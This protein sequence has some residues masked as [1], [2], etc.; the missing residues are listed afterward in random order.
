VTAQDSAR[1]GV[2][3]ATFDEVAALDPAGRKARLDAIG[4]ADPALLHAIEQLLAS[5]SSAREVLARFES[6]LGAG[7]QADDPLKLVGQVVSHFRV[8]ECIGRGGMGVVYRA[9]DIQLGRPVAVKVPLGARGAD[10]MAIERFRREARV[11]AGLEHPN[12]C[13]VYETGETPDG[14]LFYVMPFYQGE[15]LKD[16]ITRR[17]TIPIPEALG[18][19]T[20]IAGGLV[21]LHKAGI[22][23]RDLKPANVMRLEDGGVRI[24]DFGL[25]KGSDATLTAT[26]AL[27]GTIA[28]MAPEQVNGEKVDQRADLWA[29]GVVLFE[30]VTGKRPFSGSDIGAVHAI[31]HQEA[32][33]ASRHSDGVPP[34]LDDCLHRC[35]Q[36]DPG[37]RYQSAEELLTALGAIRVNERPGPLRKVRL[38]QASLRRRLTRPVPLILAGAALTALVVLVLPRRG[39]QAEPD[40]PVTVQ[41]LAILA[42]SRDADHPVDDYLVAGFSDEVASLLSRTHTVSVAARGSAA[43]LLQQGLAPRAIG[44]RLNVGHVLEA[45]FGLRSDTLLVGVQLNRVVDNGILWTHQ[46]R[47]PAS[48]VIALEREVADSLLRVLHPNARVEAAGE[49]PTRDETAYYLYLKARSAWNQREPDKLEEALTYLNGARERDPRF[50]LAYAGM[51]E[52]YVNLSN[53]RLLPVDAMLALADSAAARALSLDSTLAGAHASRGFVRASQLRYGEA[54]ASLRRSI[55]LNSDLTWAHHYYS[56]LLTMLGRL[57]EARE[58]IDKVLSLDPLSRPGMA[59]LGFLFEAEGDLPKARDQFRQALV[60][61]PNFQLPLAGL[62]TVEAALGNYEEARPALEKAV[63]LAPDFGGVRG[64]LAYVYG[65]TG[66]PAEARRLLAEARAGARDERSSINYALALANMGQLDS[67]FVV[68]QKGKWDVPTVIELRVNPLLHRFRSD[69]RYEEL[70]GRLGLQP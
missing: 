34:G 70:L 33:P 56:L 5:D 29:F 37:Q 63:R 61:A 2:I 7:G 8:L 58:Q 52:V 26:W 44:E 32:P 20:Q 22:V 18:I 13:P 67:A 15:T 59:H 10:R 6:L 55:G 60:I 9:E 46:F 3:L 39:A 66:R 40:R 45:S 64:A 23:H 19:A 47:A 50:A 65:Q 68:M 21:A 35:L 62:G 48:Q 16:A 4:R 53:Y 25:A 49:V 1:W 11:A 69:P 27:M 57:P 12:L 43:T 42:Q 51:A 38:A 30:M 28:Y 17:G 36:K 14:D 31:L 54:E 41:T 24:L